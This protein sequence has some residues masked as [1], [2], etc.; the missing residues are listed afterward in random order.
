MWIGS[1][2]KIIRIPESGKILLMEAGIRGSFACEIRH[3][4]NN[5]NSE[6]KFHWQG[7]RNSVS[8]ESGIHS[9]ESRM[10]DCLGLMGHC[11]KIWIVL[12]TGRA[13]RE[14]CFNPSGA[15]PIS[16]KYFSLAV[17]HGKFASTNQKHYSDLASDTSSAWN[18]CAYSSDVFLRW[19]RWWRRVLFSQAKLSPKNGCEGDYVVAKSLFFLLKLWRR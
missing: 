17:P 19:N 2:R 3:P 7:I 11:T 10:Q 13:A 14:I 16:Q 1:N 5:W 15:L 8:A 6:S 9:A 12:L 4:A 18:F